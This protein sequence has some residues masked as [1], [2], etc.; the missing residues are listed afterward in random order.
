[1]RR[2]TQIVSLWRL[3]LFAAIALFTSMTPA[4]TIQRFSGHVPPAVGRLHLQPIGRLPGSQRLN[5]VIGL[6]LRNRPALDD[7]LAQIY[8]PASTNYHHYLTPEQFTERF[9]PTKQDYQAA[10]AFMETNGFTVTGKHPNRAILDVIGSAGDI[11]RVFHV[12]MQVYRHPREARTFYAPDT[13]PSINLAVPILHISGLDNFSLPR[14]M[15]LKVES[16]NQ[17]VNAMGQTGSGLGGT[18]GSAD[19]RAAY[20]P[21]VSLDGSGQTVGLL[22]FDGYYTNDITAYESSNGLPNVAL[23]NV[24]ID[25]FSGPAG[26]NNGE[27]ALDIEMAIAMAPGLSGV[28]VYEAPNGDPTGPLHIL[29][30]IASDNVAKQISSSWALGDDPNFDTDYEQF[31]AQGQS[32]F[33][34]SGD[35]GAYSPGIAQWADDTNVTLVGGTTLSTTGPGG[36]WASETAWNWNITSPPY[37]NSTGGGINFNG[38]PIPGWQTGIN[39]TNNGGSMTLRNIPDVALTADNIWVIYDNGTNALFGGT[40]C[41]APLWAGFTAL[42]NQQAAAIGK[43]PVGFINPAVYALGKGVDYTTDFHDITTGNNTNRDSGNKFFAV[44]GY[45]LCTGWGTPNGVNLINALAPP[46]TLQITPAAAF[47][48][49]GPAGGPF[50]P[51]NQSFSLTNAGATSLNWSLVNTSAWLSASLTSGTL[52]AGG[53]A[54]TVTVSLNS[55]A[56][57]LPGGAY[58]ANL[59]FTNHNT[60]FVQTRLFG[61]LAGELV[62]NGGFETGDFSDWTVVGSGSA[63]NFVDDGSSSGITPHSGTYLAIFGEVGQLAYFSQVLPTSAGQSYLLS[64]WLYSLTYTGQTTPNDFLAQWNGNTLVNST[65]L[66][67]FGWTNLQFI[68]TATGP[69]TILQ[70]GGQDDPAYLGLDDVTVEPI[71][72]ILFQAVNRTNNAIQFSWNTMTGLVYQVQYKTN[73]LQTNW[74]NL[75]GSYPTTNTLMTTSD[76]IGND[77]QRFYRVWLIP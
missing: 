70:F 33:Q 52:T 43:S 20:V 47:F 21:G 36:S 72:T 48:A 54:A 68:V 41:A 66:S 9:G 73:L 14:P 17:M 29:N 28:M 25:G 55:A 15:N 39:M 22:E 16:A 37:T 56:N 12:A 57:S 2:H 63:Y 77:S 61:L 32:F 23:D 8:D 35:D 64:F 1:M 11:E 13:E 46:D 45:D 42:V 51:T 27:V 58:T 4:Q 26:T 6:P 38:I 44:P 7:L 60:G 65:N 24:Q 74:I 67:A 50:S 62:Q 75:G 31:A 53:P 40:S 10:V 69:S 19:L 76:V 34:A 30:R 49:S 18:Y 71:P 5:L 59:S 3:L